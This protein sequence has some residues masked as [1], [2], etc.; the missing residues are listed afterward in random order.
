MND[1]DE[2]LQYTLRTRDIRNNISPYHITIDEFFRFNTVGEFQD[3]LDI[4]FD[5]QNSKYNSEVFHFIY[6]QLTAAYERK[7][8][9]DLKF[10][11]IEKFCAF[12][13][14]YEVAAPNYVRKFS[15]NFTGTSTD[16]RKPNV[17]LREYLST[18]VGTR[19]ELLFSLLEFYF[20]LT[21]HLNAFATID[22][23]NFV[24]TFI[25]EVP[26]YSPIDSIP[27]LG[28]KFDKVVP[29][30]LLNDTAGRHC[31]FRSSEN[32]TEIIAERLNNELD[33]KG[34]V[35][36]FFKNGD[37]KD[38]KNITVAMLMNNMSIVRIS[39][40]IVAKGQTLLFIDSIF[41]SPEKETYNNWRSLRLPP[42]W[43][44]KIP[45]A[46]FDFYSEELA[47]MRRV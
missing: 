6:N 15:E 36:R 14:K 32:F 12:I 46:A 33:T 47:A 27:C 28:I 23:V 44:D 9:A 4:H 8:A 3:F 20:D 10:D 45:A 26:L 16:Y 43:F 11:L 21:D 7:Y 13:L 19:H 38:K 40:E 30:V 18:N 35:M 25:G 39:P 5:A 37:I 2:C 31:V 29:V 22:C 41:I 24:G 1:P 34:D 17:H 42:V